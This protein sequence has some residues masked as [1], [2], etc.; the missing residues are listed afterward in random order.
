MYKRRWPP[1]GLLSFRK[2]L[3][4][5]EIALVH[6]RPDGLDPRPALETCFSVLLAL[7]ES[8]A[9]QTPVDFAFDI[10][11]TPNCFVQETAGMALV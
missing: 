10:V 11:T 9:R 1:T 5:S 4:R 6:L 2:F 8:L 7:F 3:H